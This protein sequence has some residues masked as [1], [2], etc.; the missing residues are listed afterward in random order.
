MPGPGSV[1]ATPAALAESDDDEDAN[2]EDAFD[3]AAFEGDFAEGRVV[4]R[5]DTAT[6][7]KVTDL[8]DACRRGDLAAVRLF[9][10]NE[11]VDVNQE[12]IYQGSPLYY[13][14]LCGHSEV[15]RYLLDRGADCDPSSFAGE[16]SHYAA[17][18]DRIRA[19][20]V[21]YQGLGL[22][23]RGPLF[24]ALY[25]IYNSATSQC[26]CV[27]AVAS[28]GTAIAAHKWLLAARSPFFQKQF[29]PGGKWESKAHIHLTGPRMK[30]S[31]LKAIVS[32][33]YTERLLYAPHQ[34][35]EVTAIAKALGLE[36]LH[37]HLLANRPETPNPQLLAAQRRADE[38][39]GEGLDGGLPAAATSIVVSLAEAK[40]ST[41]NL[42]PTVAWEERLKA[43]DEEAAALDKD[44]DGGPTAA[45]ANVQKRHALIAKRRAALVALGRPLNK[46]RDDFWAK[47]VYG[48]VLPK[49][50][51]EEEDSEQ[52]ATSFDA[53]ADGGFLPGSGIPYDLAIISDGGL[54]FRCHRALVC[55]R[56]PFFRSLM[57]F[58]GRLTHTS[59]NGSAGKPP[60]LGPGHEQTEE[61]EA[62]DT[63]AAVAS[64]HDD[65]DSSSTAAASN[66]RKRPAPF[67]AKVES[68]SPIAI[69]S[70]LQM[71]Y[72]D[73]IEPLPSYEH[74]LEALAAADLL[75]VGDAKP[76]LVQQATKLFIGQDTYI[77][78]FRAGDLYLLHKLTES[79]ADF[80][81]SRLRRV[82]EEEPRFVELVR[83]SA[84]T[85]KK[86]EAYDS[87]PIIDEVLSA[88]GRRYGV[89]SAM[90]NAMVVDGTSS[91]FSGGGGAGGFA[92]GSAKVAM[93]KQ[94]AAYLQEQQRIAQGRPVRSAP[95]QTS[96][97]LTAVTEHGDDDIQ[98]AAPDD[99]EARDT[100]KEG[101][102]AAVPSFD[103]YGDYR[104]AIDAIVSFAVSLG[105]HIRAAGGKV[106]GMPHSAG[107]GGAGGR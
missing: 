64:V 101:A 26:D 91:S 7:G 1:A 27:L 60:S 106:Y 41:G 22:K 75:V 74:L 24:G 53:E 66:K 99:D 86:R 96:A 105:Y 35:D 57:A 33:I 12:D 70:L 38:G 94:M 104:S 5:V 20:L 16:R 17:L 88:V 77:D 46:L 32:F 51:F 84:A 80:V 31:A 76:L 93:G 9:V 90:A 85:V 89:S 3:D 39:E 28:D 6:L 61:A 37:R 36:E 8:F 21:R 63:A 62:A 103:G 15:A 29:G 48:G 23:Q 79:S 34:H 45:G 49:E 40:Q 30:G 98:A 83:E 2:Y 11:S 100:T 47:L 69:A 4:S 58:Q 52:E 107:A 82:L 97:A 56:S 102:A 65:V 68:V 73:Y 42:P 19:L 95:A 67:V 71:I 18:T 10:E 44:G 25:R 50:L 87:V 43:L 81:A 14:V 72:L 78:L 59:S 13:A 54:V 55:A 92:L